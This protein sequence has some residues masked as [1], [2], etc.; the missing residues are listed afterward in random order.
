MII[1]RNAVCIACCM[2][3]QR[4]M[5]GSLLVCY[6]AAARQPGTPLLQHQ[7]CTKGWT[8]IRSGT[9]RL[10]IP[11]HALLQADTLFGPALAHVVSQNS[12]RA[13]DCMHVLHLARASLGHCSSSLLENY[14]TYRLLGKLAGDYLKQLPEMQ[15]CLLQASIRSA[16]RM[17]RISASTGTP[18]AH[19]PPPS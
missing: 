19:S 12:K 9:I 11:A 10:H 18:A 17:I 6:S 5:H 16:Q 14:T 15:R 13:G 7:D 2:H 4:D 1:V 3:A 8:P